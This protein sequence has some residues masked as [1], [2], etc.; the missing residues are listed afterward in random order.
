[1]DSGCR[2]IP[3]KSARHALRLPMRLIAALIGSALA[4]VALPLKAEQLGRPSDTS[5]LVDFLRQIEPNQSQFGAESVTVKASKPEPPIPLPV[6]E[7]SVEVWR[8][9]R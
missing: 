9:E 1:M 4:G 3:S 5:A 8:E 6:E 2:H 7:V